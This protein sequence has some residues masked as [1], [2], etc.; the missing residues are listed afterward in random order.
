ML[1]AV[2]VGELTL[3]TCKLSVVDAA[4]VV[5]LHAWLV[6]LPKRK[7]TP[8]PSATACE[9]AHASKLLAGGLLVALFLCPA[10]LL[11]LLPT[12]PAGTGNSR[13]CLAN[14][15][16]NPKASCKLTDVTSDL[17][18]ACSACTCVGQHPQIICPGPCN[19][20]PKYRI[21]RHVRSFL[22]WGLTSNTAS[23]MV[24]T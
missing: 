17:C 3:Q 11:C 5:T 20:S 12:A 10:L 8:Q 9:S 14:P 19:N 4:S 2:G 16:T 24:S 1:A 21:L 13:Q 22:G 6:P 7:Q 23:A 15:L 18:C